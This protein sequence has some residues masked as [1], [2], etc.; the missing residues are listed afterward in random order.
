MQNDSPMTPKATTSEAARRTRSGR[1]M[2]RSNSPHIL[3]GDANGCRVSKSPKPKK[4]KVGKGSAPKTVKL[5][6]P[7]SILTDGMTIPVRDMEEWV[8]RPTEV[9][10][11]EVEKRNGYVTRPMNSFMLYRSAYA[12]RTK[13]WCAQNNHQV[14]SSVSGE[15]WPMEPPEVREQYNKL[16]QPN[17]QIMPR[18]IPATSSRPAKAPPLPGRRRAPTQAT[19]KPTI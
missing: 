4:A 9:R 18:L 19:R 6:G 11:K 10:E 3:K 17:E 2:A 8:N 5:E 1:S 12:E 15:S 14:V 13:M 7:L 16:P